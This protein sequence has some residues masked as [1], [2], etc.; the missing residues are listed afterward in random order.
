M[1][2]RNKELIPV[3][4]PLAQTLVEQARWQGA[5]AIRNAPQELLVA[6]QTAFPAPIRNLAVRKVPFGSAVDFIG[7]AQAF[8]LQENRS[9]FS[10]LVRNVEVDLIQALT[11]AKAERLSTGIRMIGQPTNDSYSHDQLNVPRVKSKQHLEDLVSVLS[12]SFSFP[13]GEVAE[14]FRHY[15][16]SFKY[17]SIARVGYLNS[18]PVVAGTVV[19]NGNGFATLDWVGTVPSSRGQGFA[20]CIIE[21]LKRDCSEVGTKAILLTA[22]EAGLEVYRSLGFQALGQLHT[23]LLNVR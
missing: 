19:L 21:R 7:Q 18:V 17:S 11:D 23:Y 20:R 14:S 15:G 9:R 1:N 22:T 16:G 2:R 10:A 5:R 4:T 12:A 3:S 6:G 8:F 13:E